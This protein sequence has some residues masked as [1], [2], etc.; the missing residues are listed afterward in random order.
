MYE[1]IHTALTASEHGIVS[2]RAVRRSTQPNIFLSATEAGKTT[3]AAVNYWFSELH[4]RARL[5]E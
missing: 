5:T 4:N 2:N 1:T 3:A